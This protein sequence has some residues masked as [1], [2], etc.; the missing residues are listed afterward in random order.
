MAEF[1]GYGMPALD[2][3]PL[4]QL[5]DVYKKAQ[6]GAAR[7][8]TLAQLGQGNLDYG[9]AAQAL[10]GAGD[11]EGGLALA[12]LAESHGNRAEDLQFRRDEAKRAQENSDRSYK[13]QLAQSQEKPAIVWQEDPNGGPGKVPFLVD[14]KN[15]NNIRQLTPAGSGPA[16]PPNPY[17]A[18]EKLTEQQS[19]DRLFADRTANAHMTLLGLEGDINKGVGGFLGGVAENA[20]IPGVG[21]VRDTATFNTASSVNRQKYV[22][23]QRDFVNAVLRKESGAAISPSEFENAR[24]QYFPMP[25]DSKEVIEQKR[26]NRQI[27]IEGLMQ[28][29]GRTY[30]PPANYVGTKGPVGGPAGGAPKNNDAALQQAR[31]AIA[32]GAPKDAVIKRLQENGIDPGGL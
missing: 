9:K 2:F 10:L 16:A 23:A 12:R 20:N 26:R 3:A 14:P 1:S 30:K 31:D 19:K 5:G 17:A 11:T 25:G 32:K 21:P 29:A 15:P 4:S 27:E 13:L 28:G 7:E 18:N 24:R 22:Q 6:L 8:R